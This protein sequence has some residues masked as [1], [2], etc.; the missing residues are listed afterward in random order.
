MGGDRDK[1]RTVPTRVDP[2]AG[3]NPGYA[4]KQ[5]RDRDDA[6]RPDPRRPR[7]PDEGGLDREP[8]PGADPADE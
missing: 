4:E 1:D 2:D 3:A 8:Q 7:N 5:P 6:R